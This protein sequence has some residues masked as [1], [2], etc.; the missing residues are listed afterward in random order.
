MQFDEERE[1][2][3][4]LFYSTYQLVVYISSTTSES[5]MRYILNF[6]IP[7]R[8]DRKAELDNNRLATIRAQDSILI[9]SI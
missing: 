4:P 8:K 5:K 9:L 3:R 6:F 1:V 7:G 2:E